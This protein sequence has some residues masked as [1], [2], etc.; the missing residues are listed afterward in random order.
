MNAATKLLTKVL[1]RR[2]NLVMNSLVSNFQ[3][4]FIKGRHMS[5]YILLTSKVYT[6]LKVKKGV[7]LILKLDFDKAFDTVS[8]DFLFHVLSHMNFDK[9]GYIGSNQ[10]TK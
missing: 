5:D 7:G 4:A 8:W 10:C 2:L 6:S 3:F 1:A 9:N